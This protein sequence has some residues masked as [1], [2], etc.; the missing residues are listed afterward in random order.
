MYLMKPY[1]TYLPEDD[2]YLTDDSGTGGRLTT[3]PGTFGLH[4][5][6]P[7]V[8]LYSEEYCCSYHVKDK[9]ERDPI[10]PCWTSS[11]SRSGANEQNLVHTHQAK[12][13][14]IVEDLSMRSIQVSILL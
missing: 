4:Y 12:T 13:G 14:M 2:V 5:S 3:R 9:T 11:E 7:V 6:Q 1:V 8:D 10:G